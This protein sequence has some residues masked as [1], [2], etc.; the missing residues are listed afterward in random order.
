MWI[1]EKKK[2][3]HHPK[4]NIFYVHDLDIK[5]TDQGRDTDQGQ[6][7]KE[8]LQLSRRYGSLKINQTYNP[9]ADADAR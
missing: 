6:V 5:D 8:S 4:R 2:K 7:S 9:D 1:F 3:K